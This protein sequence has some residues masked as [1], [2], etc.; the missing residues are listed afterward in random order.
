VVLAT[1]LLGFI[2]Y[3]LLPR[4]GMDAR[5]LRIVFIGLAA[6]T[7]PHMLLDTLAHAERQQ[8]PQL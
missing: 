1:L 8:R 7:V 5:L 3:G 2:A 6:L 4:I